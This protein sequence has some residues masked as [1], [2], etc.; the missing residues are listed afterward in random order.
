MRALLPP[1]VLIGAPHPTEVRRLAISSSIS[2]NGEKLPCNY[3]AT[4]AIVAKRRPPLCK[5]SK[6]THDIDA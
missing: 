2:P 1:T 6:K 5:I 4:R 3:C